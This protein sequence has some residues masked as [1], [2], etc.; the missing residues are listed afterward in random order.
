MRKLTFLSCLAF[1]FFFQGRSLYAFE[2]V[3]EGYSYTFFLAGKTQRFFQLYI[4][5]S[6]SHK[7]FVFT[8][9]NLSAQSD[10][11][12]YVYNRRGNTVA[13]S[14]ASGT[15]TEIAN[16]TPGY[17][18]YYTIKV[19]NDGDDGTRGKLYIH[20]FSWGKVLKDAIISAIKTTLVESLLKALTGTD[21]NSSEGEK[22]AVSAAATAIVSALEQKKF[23]Q[24]AKD[25]ILNQIQQEIHQRYGTKGFVVNC[26]ISFVNTYLDNIY[27]HY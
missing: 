5:S 21:N 16:F 8:L 4:S 15:S 2:S 13:A 14:N 6:E 7:T 17:S 27:Q 9:K 25:V 3:S 22:Q 1:V 26:L 18:G 11:D 10:L 19:H 23:G 20:S 24:I 12:I